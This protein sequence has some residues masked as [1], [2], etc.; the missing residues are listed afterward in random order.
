MGFLAIPT[1][2]GTIGYALAIRTAHR[3]LIDDD[4]PEPAW[5][6]RWGLATLLASGIV[7]FFAAPPIPERLGLLVD[8]S[9]VIAPL[10]VAVM[11]PVMWPMILLRWHL[12]L[13]T[14]QSLGATLLVHL[15]A[16]AGTLWLAASALL[17]FAALYSLASAIEVWL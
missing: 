3:F 17:V 14:L 16:F 9:E 5:Y 12:E 2:L 10:A 7:A 8:P 11:M 15:L 1:V 13:T 4:E 6:L